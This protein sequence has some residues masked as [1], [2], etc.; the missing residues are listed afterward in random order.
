MLLT[1]YDVNSAHTLT[2]LSMQEHWSNT[3][4]AGV[5]QMASN[6]GCNSEAHVA[7]RVAACRGLHWVQG[8]ST[9]ACRASSAPTRHCTSV[10]ISP[11]AAACRV[12]TIL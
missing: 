1:Q 8:S 3:C 5:A 9:K 2:Q 11:S 4:R 12:M 10:N 7:V 6:V